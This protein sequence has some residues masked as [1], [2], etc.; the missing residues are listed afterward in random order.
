LVIQLTSHRESARSELSITGDKALAEHILE[1]TAI[2][3]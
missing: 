2:V 1:L 3:G